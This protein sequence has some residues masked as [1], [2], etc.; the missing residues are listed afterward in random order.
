MSRERET[1]SAS[2]RAQRSNPC[3]SARGKMDCFASLAMTGRGHGLGLVGWVERS[4]THHRAAGVVDEFRLRS[5]HPT[6]PAM[7]SMPRDD[8]AFVAMHRLAVGE[9]AEA[10]PHQ[11]F[12]PAAADRAVAAAAGGRLAVVV[13][14]Q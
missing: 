2:L 10:T 8:L 13:F 9:I 14:R 11:E 4:E 3:F 6:A 7:N 12:R 1:V 5:T